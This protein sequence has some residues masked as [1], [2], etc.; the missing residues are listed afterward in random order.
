MTDRTP[1][2]SNDSTLTNKEQ[3]KAINLL[4]IDLLSISNSETLQS[5]VYYVGTWS[6]IGGIVAAT[7]SY[8]EG[9]SVFLPMYGLAGLSAVYS[10]L[11]FGCAAGLR[12]LRQ[13][14]DDVFNY[15][16]AGGI[17]AFSINTFGKGLKRGGMAGLVGLGVGSVY[18]YTSSA[19][20]S[21]SREAWL[22]YRRHQIHRSVFK[23]IVIIKPLENPNRQ[24]IDLSNPF[25]QKKNEG[26]SQ[27]T[28]VSAPA[29]TIEKSPKSNEGN[30]NKS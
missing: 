5:V 6:T 8:I 27:P 18:Y 14:P 15:A 24:E 19:V 12:I 11:F 7:S 3:P 30:T 16:A 10:S 17:S 1:D 22:G 28:K 21:F 25:K 23:Q 26:A 4:E 20:Y 13:Q 2:N 29:S 9:R